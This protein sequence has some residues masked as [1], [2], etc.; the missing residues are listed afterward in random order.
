MSETKIKV[1]FNMVEAATERRGVEWGAVYAAGDVQ[2]WHMNPAMARAGQTNADHQGRCVQLLLLLHPAPS[3]ALIRAMA[4]HD[5]GDRWAG[6]LSRDFKQAQP[7]FAAQHAVF[8]G[9]EIGRVMGAALP[10]LTADER[11]WLKLI[12]QLE[13]T[14]FVLLRAP[15]EYARRASGWRD[16]EVS[17]FAKAK[18][19]GCHVQV[20]HLIHD[21]KAGAW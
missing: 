13:A 7:E 8:E 12:D 3:S 21:L 5:L 2:R 14:C 17:L 15:G 16:A 20:R 9:A 6:D 1:T 10:Y 11:R 19:C 18:A 4:F